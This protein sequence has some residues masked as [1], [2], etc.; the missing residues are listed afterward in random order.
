MGAMQSAGSQPKNNS[1]THRQKRLAMYRRVFFDKQCDYPPP[2]V[3]EPIARKAQQ[4]E[5]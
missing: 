3:I 1:S 2:G 5:L 4:R